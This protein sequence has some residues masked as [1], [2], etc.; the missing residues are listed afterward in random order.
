MNKTINFASHEKGNTHCQR[1][2]SIQEAAAIAEGHQLNIAGLTIQSAH[3]ARRS[4]AAI[5]AVVFLLLGFASSRADQTLTVQANWNFLDC[6]VTGAGGNDLGNPAFLATSGFVS[7]ANGILNDLLYLWSGSGFN[8]YQ[9]FSGPDADNYF[10]N[11]GASSGWYDS[12]G[13]FITGLVVN[14]GQGFII[15]RPSNSSTTIT[16]HGTP[17][18]APITKPLALGTFY[19]LGSQVSG[20]GTFE[21]IGGVPPCGCATIEIYRYSPSGAVTLPGCSANCLPFDLYTSAGGVWSPSTPVLNPGESAFVRVLN[22]TTCAGS[23]VATAIFPSQGA[24][25]SLSSSPLTI[26]GNGFTGL[27]TG[28]GDYVK[29]T[30][31]GLSVPIVG[32][33]VTVLNDYQLTANFD[34]TTA[35]PGA[36]LDVEV[37]KGGVTKTI[38]SAFHVTPLMMNSVT[39]NQTANCG[40]VTLTFVGS[41]I[42]PNATVTLH[43]ATTDIVGTGASVNPDGTAITATF[44][45]TG[46]ALGNRDAI[47]TNPSGNSSSAV[48]AFSVVVTLPTQIE[49]GLIG[50]TKLGTAHTMLYQVAYRNTGNCAS[51]GSVTID[52]TGI[53]STV[54]LSGL[55]GA[56]TATLISGGFSFSV[57]SVSPSSGYSYFQFQLQGQPGGTYPYTFTLSANTH[58]PYTT[59]TSCDIQVS[60]AYDPNDKWGLAGIG[61]N[62][63][64]TGLELLPYM[65][66]FENMPSASAPA[67]QVFV[68]DQ[69]DTS[70]FDLNTFSLG[71]ITFGTHTINPPPGL[72]HFTTDVLFD[73]DGNPATGDDDMLVRIVADLETDPL[74]AN[75]GKFTCN[76]IS[77]DPLTGLLPTD[78]T[79]GFLPPNVTPP[80]GEGS[81]QF[82]ISAMPGLADGAVIPNGASIVFDANAPILTPI[83]QNTLDQS[84][85]VSAVAALPAV[86][87]STSFNVTWSGT[88]AGSGIASYDVWVSDNGAA[89]TPW[90][91]GTTS[92]SALYAGVSGHT[93]GF[94]SVAHDA[95]GYLEDAPATPDALTTVN[96]STLQ[97]E[98]V[99]TQLKV[100]WSGGTLEQSSELPGGWTVAPVQ[101]SPWSF[102]PTAAKQFFRVHVP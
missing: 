73:V 60:S 101:V 20:P 63:Y 3:L 4:I 21:S 7:D 87:T 72:K 77:I 25:C 48:N 102:T 29:L 1:K 18:S 100:T 32:T 79:R 40:P 38:A 42:C 24:R 78:P 98:R 26:V 84:K 12:S 37:N 80:D 71:P 95:M 19:L 65:V 22:C 11:S 66:H 88:D 59:S 46:V 34:L 67:Q 51:V 17:I 43:D 5:L 50:S 89:A 90:L 14:P 92:T 91:T 39:P 2:P 85:P 86:T 13:N 36:V 76:Y 27:D 96:T 74:S 75:Y 10:L 55:S 64:I 56:V 69:L 49:V 8:I 15:R 93:Y 97:I 41:G 45:L 9:F 31:G 61:A 54:T 94:Y 23:L 33:S 81:V 57:P 52:V 82:T 35:S 99:G 28:S 6:A 62:H 16:L 58:A 70:K 68:T 53:P 44:D 47:I 30:G 83:W